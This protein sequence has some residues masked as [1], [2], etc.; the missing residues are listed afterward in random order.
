MKFTSFIVS[1]AVM[2][3]VALATNPIG[4]SCDTPN[5]FACGQ[6]ASLNNG[7]PF[8]YECSPVTDEYVYVVGCLC[9]TCCIT[10][11]VGGG[12]CVVE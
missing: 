2:A 10:T 7:N 4:E 6:D 11:P 8:V 5:V 9:P 1:V 12:F 3:G